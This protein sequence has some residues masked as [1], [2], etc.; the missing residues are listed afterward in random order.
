MLEYLFFNSVFAEKFKRL[1]KQ[2]SLEFEQKAE[3]VQNAILITTSE[4]IDDDL[5]DEI[6][7]AYD[8]LALQDQQLLQS[9]LEDDSKINTAGIYIQLKDEQQ[10]IASIEP[11]VMNRM[12]E[13]ISMDEFNAFIEAIVSAVEEPDETPFCKRKD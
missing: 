11:D 13:K 5:W 10:T 12:L 1:L 7:E 3:S 4:D 6:D 9:K 8:D 2:K